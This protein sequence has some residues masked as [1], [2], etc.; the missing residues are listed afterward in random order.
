MLTRRK[1]CLG[2]AALLLASF[3]IYS[4][5]SRR[6][7]HSMAEGIA[8]LTPDPA[9]IAADRA[10]SVPSPGG[11]DVLPIPPPAAPGVGSRITFRVLDEAR[12]PVSGTRCQAI[13]RGS[14]DIRASG[15]LQP[16]LATSQADGLLEFPSQRIDTS[17]SFVF[18]HEGYRQATIVLEEGDSLVKERDVILQRG[19]QQAFRFVTGDGTPV[20][21]S[22]VIMSQCTL[23][24]YFSAGPETCSM[25]G[26][27]LKVG[28][29]AGISGDDGVAFVRGLEVGQYRFKAGAEGFLQVGGDSMFSAT[30][31]GPQIE[32][33][34]SPP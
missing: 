24:S 33:E 20:S 1:R 26:L 19:E 15:D 8:S 34:C 7:E 2:L 25:P 10:I 13:G 5:T 11:R 22:R 32:Y 6:S 12:V 4:L 27:P 16:C 23:P 14:G 21:G 28:I 3:G 30:V 29:R 31:P 9:A 18:T 17:T